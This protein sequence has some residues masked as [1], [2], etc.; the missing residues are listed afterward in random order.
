MTGKIHN[1]DKQQIMQTQ[2]PIFS[3]VL[4]P[5]RSLGRN[6]FIALMVFVALTCFISGVFFLVAG[7]WPV[8]IAMGFDVLAIWIA[9]K[10][11]YHSARRY[12]EVT[13]SPDKLLIRKVSPSGKCTE[14]L[15]NP[16][17]VKFLVEKH[18]KIGVVAMKLREAGKELELGAFLNPDDRKSFASAFNN[19]LADARR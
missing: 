7:A 5:Y 19:A 12:E 2:H 10:V 6:G 9:F 14:H 18:D 17:W 15:F 3:V 8:M 4:T 13:L 11:N 16:F 1:L